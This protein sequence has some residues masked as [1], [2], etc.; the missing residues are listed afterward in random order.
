MEKFLDAVKSWYKKDRKIIISAV[1]AGCLTTICFGAYTKIYSG[2]IGKGIADEVIRFHVL[3]NSDSEADQALKLKVK[4][5]V[6]EK[7]RPQLQAA[8]TRDDALTF[9]QANMSAIEQYANEVVKSEGYDYAVKASME[10]TDFPTKQYLNTAFPAGEYDALRIQIG[11]AEGQNWWCVMF[12]PLCFVDVTKKEI[13]E[14]EL[15]MLSTALTKEEFNLVTKATDEKNI[16]IKIKFKIVEVWNG[17]KVKGIV[18]DN[19]KD[20]TI[21]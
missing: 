6:L 21:R 9:L 15:Q 10:K 20:F 13:P 14:K 3:A 7:F 19:K 2:S 1:F 11:T 12:P 17:K 8:E 4:D 16:P 18:K 5:S